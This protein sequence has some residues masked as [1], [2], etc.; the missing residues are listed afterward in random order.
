MTARVVASA[1]LVATVIATAIVPLRVAMMLIDALGFVLMGIG[2]G[3]TAR[4]FAQL[5][6]PGG[7]VTG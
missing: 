5:P 3:M 7:A 6:D 1:G 4:T 2:F